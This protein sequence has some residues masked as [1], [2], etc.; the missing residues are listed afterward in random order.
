MTPPR[1][2]DLNWTGRPR[3]I[4][5]ALLES[6]GV[7]ALIDPG[8]SSTLPTLRAHLQSH[9][10][11][12]QDLDT[13]LLTHI[14]LDHAGAAG[15]LVR[16]NPRLSVYV[17]ERG[18]PH[19]A[20][21]AKLLGSAARLYADKMQQLYGDF[22][23]VPR[24]NLRELRGGE[25]ISIGDRALQVLYTPGH[26]S[27]HVTFWDPSDHTA[28]VGDTAGICVEG[29]SFILPAVPPPDI[30]LEI[31]HHSLDEILK[32]QPQ[33]LF[34]TH[35]G[36]ADRPAEHIAHYRERM[37]GWCDLAERL[38]RENQNGNAAQK[39]VEETAAEI[40]RAHTGPEAEHYIFNG[41]LLLSWLGLERYLRKRAAAK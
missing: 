13:I 37:R 18:A 17:H 32:L 10:L 31:W 23:P 15:S 25:S 33:R 24:E 40:R 6:A 8:P 22:L 4:G 34:L 27:H 11:T 21:P 20:D 14:H 12:V 30:D 5:S 1:I 2:F 19:M 3:S 29:D 36:F 38:L 7:R 26:A 28:Y 9:G 39:F 16:E 35:F 41:G